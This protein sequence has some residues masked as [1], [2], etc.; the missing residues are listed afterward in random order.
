MEYAILF[1]PLIGSV[2]GYFGRSITKYFAEISTSLFVCISALLSI[3]V[4]GMELQIIFM[5]TILYLNG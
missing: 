1:L 5:E 2:L 4:F 3:F